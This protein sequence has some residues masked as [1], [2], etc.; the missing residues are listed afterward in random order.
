MSGKNADAQL[1]VVI[2]LAAGQGRRFRQSGGTVHKLDALLGGK[3][4][5]ERVL[6]T[7]ATSGL[8]CHIVRP[9]QGA[10]TDTQGIG[11]SIARGVQATAD[12]WGWLI[13]PGDLPLVRAQS[14]LQVARELAMQPV[15]TPFWNG[16]QG[17][18][19]GFRAE[20][21]QA[22]TLLRGDT[23]AASV[24]RAYRQMGAVRELHLDDPGI[25]TDIDT[26]ENLA[27]A[28]ELLSSRLPSPQPEPVNERF[29]GK[30]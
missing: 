27:Q 8:E 21:F 30:H 5:L 13:L 28:E 7:V 18:P 9:E 4:L 2:V 15:V 25:T 20:C 23:G 3:T 19:V 16:Q 12:A 10:C 29:Y 26:L 17:H 6:R 1:P 14:L 11:D 24:V 22:L